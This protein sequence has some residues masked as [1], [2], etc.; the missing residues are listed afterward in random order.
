MRISTNTI[1]E[2]ATN[3]LGS[4]QTQI[5]RTQNQL[6]TNK[7]MLAASDDPIAAAR[8]LEVT[9]SRSMNTQFAT[10]RDNARAALSLEENALGSTTDLLQ[11]VQTLLVQAGN[12][13]MSPADRTAMA[14]ELQGRLDD[15]IGVANTGDGS[16]GYLFSGY[17]VDVLPYTRT[18]N[19]AQYNGDQ[20]QRNLQVDSSRKLPVSDPGSA[21]FDRAPTGN[22][23]FQVKAAGGNTGSGVVSS[24]AVADSSK[25]LDHKYSL[26]F[27]VSG[28]TT[29]YSITDDSTGE[30]LPRPPAAP[31]QYPFTSGQQITFD[32][33]AFDIKG[34]PADGDVF[35]VEPSTKQPM[36][37]TIANVI[38]ALRAPADTE[39]GKARL[40]NALSEASDNL[41]SAADNVLTVQA[42]VGARLKELDYLDDNGSGIDIEYATTLSKLQDLDMAKAISQ[43][44]AQQVTLQAAQQSFKVVS[45]LS[46][47]NYIG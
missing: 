37:T 24:G 26:N 12:G 5:A 22:G 39:A 33:M 43:F 19:G 8:A 31:V 13:A 16:G 44:S 6:A 29:T 2:T 47:F 36:F 20:G 38:T 14:Q 45:G 21:I 30:Q 40:G 10:N 3:Q 32:G 35:K 42:S 17:K 23:T 27:T 9:Q 4:L 15:L 41:K 11:A 7:R 28:G 34:E 1:Y 25:I 46:L 18:A